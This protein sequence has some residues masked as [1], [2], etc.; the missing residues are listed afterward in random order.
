MNP[1]NLRPGRFASYTSLG[2][3]L[4]ML[5]LRSA[6]QAANQDG[7]H[8]E[9]NGDDPQDLS[10]P[11]P[12]LQAEVVAEAAEDD[13]GVLYGDAVDQEEANPRAQDAENAKHYTDRC[14]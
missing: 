5:L 4:L 9:Y 3:L 6:R 14:L 7:D 1:R 10:G 12:S 2:R 11:V 13:A 8:A